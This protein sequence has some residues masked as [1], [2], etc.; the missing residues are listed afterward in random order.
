MSSHTPLLICGAGPTGLM[1]AAQLIRFNIDFLIIDAKAGPTT[2]SRAVV[3]QAR[4]L[5]IYEQMGLSD[6][7]MQNSNTATGLCFWRDGKRISEARLEDFGEDITP[8]HFITIYEQSKNEA[9]LYNYLKQH[10]KDVSWQTTLL[11][12]VQREKVFEVKLQNG[13]KEYTLTTD[14]LIA[15][16]GAKSRLR[17]LSG[18]TFSGGSYQQVFY[19]ADTHI[20]TPVCEHKLNFF[21]SRETFHLLFP[22][23][24]K[25]R[26]RA[27]GILPPEFYHQDTIT[28]TE[29]S[30]AI[31][32]DAGLPLQFYDTQWYSTYRLHHKKVTA[33]SQGNL[34]FCG[35]AAHV[36]S[37]A[38][39]QG[40]NTGLQ[41]ACNLA[42]KLA[43]VA[44]GK[45]KESLLTTYHEERN[46]VAEQLLTTTD[47]MFGMMAN[48]NWVDSLLRLYIFPHLVPGLMKMQWLRKKAFEAVS[49]VLIA[50]TGLSLSKGK[51]GSFKAGER[52]PYCKLTV[53][54][55]EISL[56]IFV[57]ERAMKPFLLL[58]Y[59]VVL[60]KETETDSIHHAQIE[61]NE[62]NDTA[63]AKAGLPSSFL[64]LLRPDYYIG[65]A[66]EE[67]DANEWQSYLSNHLQLR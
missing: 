37:P 28:F 11:S 65:Y 18:M 44:N 42:W 47:K 57:R 10:G 13:E 66:A 53:D 46:P 24:G 64:L 56:F 8:F 1:M 36:H 35:D 27:I 58:S 3:V 31:E 5:E 60:P 32:K 26:Y 41:D 23:E 43:L 22:M 55:K 40:M 62:M 17:E 20:N 12:Y 15:C 61:A 48:S 30:K 39:G 19:V 45:A 34:F 2:E 7:V 67:F 14:Y 59:R 33:F 52:L 25:N 4:S 38:G 54:G 50:Y 51:A 6:D 29:V 16:D 49:Q 63:F 9:L 21:V